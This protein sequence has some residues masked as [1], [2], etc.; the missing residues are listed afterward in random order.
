MGIR[1]DRKQASWSG[2]SRKGYSGLF[3]F[4]VTY[5]HGDF[6]EPLSVGAHH[7][8][9]TLKALGH[10]ARLMPAKMCVRIPKVKRMTIAMRKRS[11]RRCN[12]QP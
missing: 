3:Q 6:T 7:L 8:S 12:A 4:G 5:N 2:Q 10:D 9:C 11:P 1:T